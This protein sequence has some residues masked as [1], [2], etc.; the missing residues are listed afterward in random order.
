MMISLDEAII[1]AQ[2]ASQREDLCAECRKEHEQLAN[3]LI[4]LRDYKRESK[5]SKT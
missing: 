2:E 1:H 3:W 5:R 4:E